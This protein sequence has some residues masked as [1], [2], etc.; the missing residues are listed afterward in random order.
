LGVEIR[1]S[2]FLALPSLIEK[3][4]KKKSCL[5]KPKMNIFV[6]FFVHPYAAFNISEEGSNVQ[7]WIIEHLLM[8]EWDDAHTLLSDKGIFLLCF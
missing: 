7:S 1:V 8:H 2:L 3:I 5:L 4:F 6:P